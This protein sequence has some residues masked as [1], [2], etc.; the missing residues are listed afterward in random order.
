[1]WN[2]P[3]NMYI[4]I[5]VED[6]Y[7]SHWLTSNIKRKEDEKHKQRTKCKKQ[8]N[9]FGGMIVYHCSNTANLMWLPCGSIFYHIYI[10]LN[11]A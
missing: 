4:Y 2:Y 7:I 11:V 1:M 8:I 10:F 6:S 9:F 5:Y 3:I